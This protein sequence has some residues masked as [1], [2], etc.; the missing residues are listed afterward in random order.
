MAEVYFRTRKTLTVEVKSGE[1]DAMERA[2]GGGFG[3]RVF[4]DGR[5]GFY[6]STVIESARQAAE[7]ALKSSE[8]TTKDESLDLP[9]PAEPEKPDVFDPAAA[10]IGE[11]SAI[12]MARILEQAAFSADPRIKKIRK[13]LV[14]FSAIDTFIV[15][16]KGVSYGNPSTFCTA[17]ITVVAEDKGESRMG[18]DFQGGRF[19]GDVSVEAVGKEAARRALLALGSR[20]M[21]A[22]K[23]HVVLDGSVATEFFSLFVSMLS[24]EAV[25]KGKSLLRG[26][27]GRR[28]MGETVDIIDDG[29]MRRGP[30]TRHV[31]DEG[32]P[33]RKNVFVKEG[34]LQGFMYN[35]HTAKKEGVASTG[36][37]VRGGYS[38]VPSVGPMNVYIDSS[39]KRMPLKEMLGSLNK[40]LYVMEA[41]GMHTANPV[42][43]DFS[44]G[45]SGLWVE[46]GLTV[47]PVKEAVISG[48]LLDFFGG[49]MAVGDELRFYGNVGS[50]ALLMAP[51]DISA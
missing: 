22:G 48:N 43:G 24:S 35:T 6:Y 3:L 27:V 21:S 29:L 16:S 17:Q 46:D 36:N 38:S 28:V 18:W 15:N 7:A 31:D 9:E 45:V 25:Q 20:R 40:G 10:S 8:F 32:V 2:E 49:V 34:V 44:I 33:A 39:S 4:R 13:A 12:E 23:A 30:G 37:A 1:V 42:S 5:A 50:P 26:R 51:T 14:S 11:E 41:M 47:F 19:L